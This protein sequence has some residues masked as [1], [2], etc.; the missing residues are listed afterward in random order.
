MQSNGA[1][2]C[3]QKYTLGGELS[4][5]CTNG[6]D[7]PVCLGYFG[8][9]D[10]QKVQDFKEYVRIASRHGAD[11]ACSRKQLLIYRIDSKLDS[12]INIASD[13]QRQQGRSAFGDADAA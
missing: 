2:I 13:E 5:S 4:G 7:S 3:F 11:H 8:R 1:V 6:L 10:V 9:V 12:E